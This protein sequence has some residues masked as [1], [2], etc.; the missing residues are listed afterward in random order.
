MGSETENENE[1][2]T[3]TYNQYADIPEKLKKYTLP[4]INDQYSFADALFHYD[5]N[6]SIYVSY[7]YENKYFM[8]HFH[9]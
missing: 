7:L 6:S 2:I 4:S 1:E 9:E 8:T 5:G 3:E